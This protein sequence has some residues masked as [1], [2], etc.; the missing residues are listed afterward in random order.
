MTHLFFTLL[1]NFASFVTIAITLG[2]LVGSIIFY[3]VYTSLQKRKITKLVTAIILGLLFI[4]ITMWL[5]LNVIV[6]LL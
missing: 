3:F 6:N 4:G 5:F 2:I 1:E